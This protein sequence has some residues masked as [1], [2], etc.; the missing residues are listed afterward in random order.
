MKQCENAD[1]DNRS[2]RPTPEGAEGRAELGRGKRGSE[3]HDHGSPLWRLLPA[4][5]WLLQLF[6]GVAASIKLLCVNRIP[7]WSS[8]NVQ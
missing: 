2:R 5:K 4:C 8:E 7:V 1:T 3:E 6:R